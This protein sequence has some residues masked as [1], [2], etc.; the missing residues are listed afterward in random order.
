MRKIFLLAFFYTSAICASSIPSLSLD[1]SHTTVSG[2]S[3][4]GY[5]AGQFHIAHSDWVKGV[6]I[7]AA[8]P[9]YC[10]ENSLSVALSRCINKQE[11]IP[12]QKLLSHI[13]QSSDAAKIADI[14]H[15]E[16]AKVWIFHGTK[17]E[18]VNQSVT[19]ALAQQ[20]QAL[21]K[22]NQL[23]YVNTQPFAHHF[24]TQSYGTACDQ[25]VAPYLGNCEY[26]A[27][28]NMLSFILPNVKPAV[29]VSTGEII[30][31]NQ[32]QLGGD[33][34]STLAETGYLYIP[35]QCKEGLKCQLHISFHGCN[36]YSA[37]ED[38]GTQYVEHTGLNQF[39]DSNDF[40]VFYPQTK[41][42]LYMP[43]NPQGCW[44]WWGYTGADYSTRSGKQIN[45]VTQIVQSLKS[46]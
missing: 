33:S 9:Y 42:S 1:L 23:E 35:K 20:Y 29:A 15:L 10:A 31:I 27:A 8:G 18:K 17:D 46:N 28:A 40:V 36:Q 39:A 13:K 14:K 32:Q 7:I 11:T 43:M 4:G 2:I 41:K 26:N 22:N 6:A 24:P 21:I 19:D 38:I 12:L 30:A 45:A 5:M 25:S 37:A 16:D 44:D 34:A 3:S